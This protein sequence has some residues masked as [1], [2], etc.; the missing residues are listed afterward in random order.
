MDLRSKIEGLKIVLTDET[1]I[2]WDDREGSSDLISIFP[3]TPFAFREPAVKRWEKRLGDPTPD[4]AHHVGTFPIG[5]EVSFEIDEVSKVWTLYMRAFNGIK[6]EVRKLEVDE[7]ES[8]SSEEMGFF[9]ALNKIYMSDEKGRGLSYWVKWLDG[10][11]DG[12]FFALSVQVHPQDLERDEY[13]ARMIDR[14]ESIGKILRE[15]AQRGLTF[16]R[17]ARIPVSVAQKMSEFLGMD[18]PSK[19]EGSLLKRT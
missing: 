3:R 19:E 2:N 10:Y 8:R 5:S 12:Q 13:Y 4:G 18:R 6:I 15:P 11:I 17:I 9:S 1:G 14:A 16:S 7:S